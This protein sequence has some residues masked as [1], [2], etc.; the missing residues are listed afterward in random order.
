MTDARGDVVITAECSIGLNMNGQVLLE[1]EGEMYFVVANTTSHPVRLDLAGSIMFLPAR[2]CVR[3]PFNWHNMELK[4]TTVP[5]SYKPLKIEAEENDFGV[6]GNCGDDVPVHMVGLDLVPFEKLEPAMDRYP[7]G[8]SIDI[9]V[10]VRPVVI[11]E[12]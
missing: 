5:I 8:D 3:V 12:V 6:G 11:P 2:S 9:S 4:P 1:P 7:W 10:V